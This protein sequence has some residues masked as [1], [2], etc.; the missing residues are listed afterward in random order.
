MK[1]SDFMK[2]AGLDDEALAARVGE[3]SAHAVKKWRYQE[4]VPRPEQMRRI[5]EIT[6]GKVTPNDFVLSPPAEGVSV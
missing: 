1:L 2:A 4:R 3:C 6:E 5:A